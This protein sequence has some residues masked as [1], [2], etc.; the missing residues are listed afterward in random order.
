M[1]RGYVVRVFELDDSELRD[2]TDRANMA[3]RVIRADCDPRRFLVERDPKLADRV[4]A[5]REDLS[6]TTVFA[7]KARAKARRKK[8]AQRLRNRGHSV[9]GHDEW[10][11]VYVIELDSTGI[12]DSGLGYVYVGETSQRVEDRFEQHRLGTVEWSRARG[13]RRV[14]AKAIRLRPDLADTQ[15]YRSRR[16]SQAAEARLAARLREMGFLVEGGR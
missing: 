9:L 4:T 6:P 15:V 11:R 12:A 1:R 16:A 8:L 5:V 13:S 2:R 14:G 3:V 7:T 10:F